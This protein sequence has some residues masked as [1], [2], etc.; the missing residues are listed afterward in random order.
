[1]SQPEGQ[2]PD[3]VHEAAYARIRRVIA[4]NK[5]FLDKLAAFEPARLAGNWKVTLIQRHRD[6]IALRAL[7]AKSAEFR[8]YLREKLSYH[9]G[10]AY[11]EKLVAMFLN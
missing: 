5:P 1:M 6:V 7:W 9:Y 3:P 4:A 11:T 10:K 8:A 2:G